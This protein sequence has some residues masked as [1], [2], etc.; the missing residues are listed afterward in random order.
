LQALEPPAT[1][2]DVEMLETQEQFQ[3]DRRLLPKARRCIAVR[4]AEPHCRNVFTA[5]SPPSIRHPVILSQLQE[6]AARRE[7]VAHTLALSALSSQCE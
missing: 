4:S 2:M 5:R 1:A 3:Y 6:I 7:Q